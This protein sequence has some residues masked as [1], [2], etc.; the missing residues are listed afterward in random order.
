MVDS[1]LS[2]YVSK[3]QDKVAIDKNNNE[4]LM[5]YL[6]IYEKKFIAYAQQLSMLSQAIKNNEKVL[7]RK[8]RLLDNYTLIEKKCQEALGESIYCN[9]LLN[10]KYFDCDCKGQIDNDIQRRLSLNIKNAV[11]NIRVIQEKNLYE[12]NYKNTKISLQLTALSFILTAIGLVM[13]IL[14]IILTIK[15]FSHPLS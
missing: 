10:S 8:Y 2:A 1:L 12:L 14:G 6:R 5:H 3:I 11:D 9:T 15:S 13:A 7:K 4:P